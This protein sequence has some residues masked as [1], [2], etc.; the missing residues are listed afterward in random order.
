[1]RQRRAERDALL[2]AARELAREGVGTIEQADAL[3]ELASSDRRRVGWN[4]GEPERQGDE[5]RRGQLT[6]ERAPVVLV[7]IPEHVPA[8]PPELA[9]GRI[10]ERRHRQRRA[11]PPTA[12]AR[13]ARTRMKRRLPGPARA[14]HDADLALVDPSSVSPCKRGDAACGGR[15]DGEQFARVDERRHSVGLPVRGP[16]FTRERTTRR[17]ADE[18]SRKD[19]KSTTPATTSAGST[20]T[21][22]GGSASAPR[23][24]TVT[25]RVTRSKSAR[26]VAMPS[27]ETDGRDR[28]RTRANDSPQ[29]RRRS[30]LR[31][32][33]EV[34]AAVVAQVRAH[35]ERQA[36]RGE[37]ERE[38]LRSR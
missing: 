34:L 23:A 32:E 25:T 6:L 22:S 15:V 17:A 26:P 28:R 4:G 21:A 11:R 1:M 35:G 12:G 24:V 14:E 31:L 9:G 33:V 29:E 27:D 8:I 36:E 18:E 37:K 38:R 2:L 20:T 13:P 5:L 3:E 30:T 19:A 10:R 16:A 7:R